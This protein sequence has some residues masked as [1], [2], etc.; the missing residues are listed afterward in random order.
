M[1]LAEGP[2]RFLWPEAKMAGQSHQKL[3][4]GIPA[5]CCF[6]EIWFSQLCPLNSALMGQF[7][8]VIWIQ[9]LR[10]TRFFLSVLSRTCLVFICSL[11][12]YTKHSLIWVFT[13][14]NPLMYSCNI[15]LV[16]WVYVMDP[17]FPPIIIPLFHF[18]AG[19]LLPSYIIALN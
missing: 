11:L 3:K 1:L 15:L 7:C 16:K 2:A 17:G 14:I 10:G 8:S 9:R 4:G 5:G 13:Q 12:A 18:R 19:G 6:P